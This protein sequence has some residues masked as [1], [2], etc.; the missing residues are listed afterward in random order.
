MLVFK[1]HSIFSEKIHLTNPKRLETDDLVSWT[2]ILIIK[3]IYIFTRPLYFMLVVLQYSFRG[4]SFFVLLFD[5]DKNSG[6]YLELLSSSTFKCLLFWGNFYRWK[7][8]LL[9][10]SLFISLTYHIYH[11]NTDKDWRIQ[12]DGRN[13]KEWRF[14]IIYI[15]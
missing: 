4:L 5:V 14:R 11:T 10:F 9:L 12:Y 6:S 7:K 13:S 2:A 8:I 3:H 15:Q 1:L